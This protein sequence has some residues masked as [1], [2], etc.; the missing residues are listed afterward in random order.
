MTALICISLP[1]AAIALLLLVPES[2]SWLAKKGK[3]QRAEDAFFWCRGHSIEAKEEMHTMLE[4]QRQSSDRHLTLKETG[5]LL[6]QPEFYKPLAIMNVF[7]ITTQF[8]GVNAI[9]FYSV[10]IMQDTVGDG[11]NEYASMLIID[12]IRVVMSLVAC[13]LLRRFGRRP[14]AVLSGFGTAFSLFVLC[15]FMHASAIFKSLSDYAVVP[16]GSLV[17]YI[18]FVSLGLVPLPW[19]MM[20]EVFPL[21]V[22][23]FGSGISSSIAFIAFFTVVKTSPMMFAD[24][25]K[26]NTFLVYGAVAFT[27]T[28]FLWLFL[29][30]TKNKTLQEVEEYFKRKNKEHECVKSSGVI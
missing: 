6:L 29:P 14:L 4:K 18:S 9:T 26:A 27:G 5:R 2:P 28:L 22:R 7:F 24:I 12:T 30:E 16:L 1:C 17:G 23:G 25:G 20:G 15:A 13:I 11:L 21:A 10:S 19:A 8:C 3:L